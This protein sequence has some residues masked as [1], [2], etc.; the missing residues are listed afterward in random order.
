MSKYEK[1]LSQVVR[2]TSDSNISFDDLCQ[3]LQRIGFNLRIR[4]S[5]YIFDRKDVAELTNLQ[6]EVARQSLT[7]FGK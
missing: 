5:H 1:L 3:L 6:K 2:G 4:G 7:K